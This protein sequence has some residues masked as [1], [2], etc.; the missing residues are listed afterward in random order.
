MNDV[1][2]AFRPFLSYSANV[3]GAIGRLVVVI[4]IAAEDMPPP[5]TTINVEERQGQSV[6]NFNI[7]IIA[8]VIMVHPHANPMYKEMLHGELYK[9]AQCQGVCA[10]LESILI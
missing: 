1:T 3:P 7:I 8:I 2:C 5:T 4:V 9:C 6:E 10:M